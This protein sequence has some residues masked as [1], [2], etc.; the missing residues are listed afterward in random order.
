MIFL[1]AIP[2]AILE[3]LQ[4][5][6]MT[7]GSSA[8]GASASVINS[9]VSSTATGGGGMQQQQPLGQWFKPTTGSGD[10]KKVPAQQ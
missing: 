5:Q 7:G 10:S 3:A 8:G 4:A 9:S 6:S 2:A 1:A